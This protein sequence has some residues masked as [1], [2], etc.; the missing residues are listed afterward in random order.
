MGSGRQGAVLKRALSS[1]AL[2]WA[3]P[4]IAKKKFIGPEKGNRKKGT[5]KRFRI[6]HV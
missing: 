3:A 4:T 2:A 5:D 6:I 1:H